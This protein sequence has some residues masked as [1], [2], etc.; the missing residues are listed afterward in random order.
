MFTL[1]HPPW[2]ELAGRVRV[3]VIWSITVSYTHLVDGLPTSSKE[4]EQM[5]Q[6]QG[7]VFGS[8]AEGA[9]DRFM[10]VSYTHLSLYPHKTASS[11]DVLQ[12]L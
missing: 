4:W 3:G 9:F 11:L 5:I 10:A 6:S 12:A 8:Y 1:I 2:V 7:A